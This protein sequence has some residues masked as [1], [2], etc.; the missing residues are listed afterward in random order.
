MELF[1]VRDGNVAKVAF[2]KP[3]NISNVLLQISTTG[4]LAISMTLIMISG[5]IDLSVGQ[6]MCFLG[7]GMAFLIRNAGFSEPAMVLTGVTVAVLC[8]LLMGFDHLA[9]E[10]GA[11]HRVAGVHDHL[12]GL[13][14][15]DHQR[16]RNHH[17]G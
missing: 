3:M 15:P 14:L 11:V 10:T 6:M 17:H 1:V 7:T 2:L 13:H 9:D 4:I 8:E 16:Q 12:H 5:G